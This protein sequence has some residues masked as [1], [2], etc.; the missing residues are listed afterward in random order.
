M[1][2]LLKPACPTEAVRQKERHHHNEKLVRRNEA[3]ALLTSTR[4]HPHKAMTSAVKNKKL[5]KNI[6]YKY[7]PCFMGKDRI[8]YLKNLFKCPK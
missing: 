8:K 1:P 2:Q 6:Y 4:E 5:K 7:H 3:Q